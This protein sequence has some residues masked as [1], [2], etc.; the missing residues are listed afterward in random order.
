MTSEL[1]RLKNTF[2]ESFH[3]HL[4]T[5]GLENTE[6]IPDL[7]VLGLDAM[8]AYIG[9]KIYDNYYRHGTANRPPE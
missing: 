5:S 1:L 4:Y 9:K 2:G 3:I 7:A 6:I 8:G